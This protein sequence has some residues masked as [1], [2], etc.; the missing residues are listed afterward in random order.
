MCKS[1]SEG[2]QRCYAHAKKALEK[3]QADHAARRSSFTFEAVTKAEV[4]VAST[5]TGRAEYEALAEAARA[6]GDANTV[7]RLELLIREGDT[8]RER[9]NEVARAVARESA[10]QGPSYDPAGQPPDDIDTHLAEFLGQKSSVEHEI[11]TLAARRHMTSTQATRLGGLEARRAHLKAQLDRIDEEWRARGGWERAWVV[12]GGHAHSSTACSTCYPTTKFG[13][14]PSMSGKSQAE[15]VEAAGE[16]ACTVC[17]PTAPVSTLSRPTRLFTREEEAEN[18]KRASAA[19]ARAAAAA[20]RAS[21]AITTPSGEPL[22]DADGWVV[23]TEVTAE[24]QAVDGLANVMWYR[25]SSKEYRGEEIPH[26]TEPK[27]QD[28]AE[29]AADALA[30]KRG[31]TADEVTTTLKTKALAKYKR[32]CKEAGIT[33]MY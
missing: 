12:P 22:K 27:W 7:Q 14:V 32:M 24:R 16:R 31:V 19:Q 2:G 1:L 5:P 10:Q 8:R 9:N 13:L 4:D 17:Y 29:R 3:A 18:T 26:P 25:H 28:F 30:A 15:I 20:N 21:K 6:A 11:S 33:P 23:K